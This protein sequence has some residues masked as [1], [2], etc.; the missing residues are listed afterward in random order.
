ME[1]KCI[2]FHKEKKEILCTI[3]T[4]ALL[5]FLRVL[6]VVFPIIRYNEKKNTKLYRT[7]LT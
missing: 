6:G 7:P 4:S 3:K 5:T 1:G 2:C